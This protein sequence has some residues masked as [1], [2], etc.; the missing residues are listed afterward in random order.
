MLGSGERKTTVVAANVAE[1]DSTSGSSKD[2]VPGLRSRTVR[3]FL[4]PSLYLT[5]L[6]FRMIN[7]ISG[8]Y[9]RNF[10]QGVVSGILGNMGYTSSQ[11]YKL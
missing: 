10:S 2:I 6:F 4:S 7:A 5:L 9:G 1:I 8:P 3:A 11:V